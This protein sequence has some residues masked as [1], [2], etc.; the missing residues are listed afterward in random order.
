MCPLLCGPKRTKQ[1][2]VLQRRVVNA[3]SSW[4]WRL[5]AQHQIKMSAAPT[6]RNNYDMIKHQVHLKN[7]PIVQQQQESLVAWNSS[8]N[9]MMTPRNGRPT[10]TPPV[11][12]CCSG[13]AGL[14]TEYSSTNKKRL[15]DSF[16]RVMS[17]RPRVVQVCR[18]SFHR[19]IATPVTCGG[20]PSSSVPDSKS[21]YASDTAR[22][23]NGAAV[24]LLLSFCDDQ[25][26]SRRVIY[27]CYHL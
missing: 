4:W 11:I 9:Y 20:K 19:A 8:H 16:R 21:D 24:A 26:F 18:A 10:R 14:V 1:L 17:D 6:I 5:H 3:G 13:A 23:P 12:N 22:S 27:G 7:A 2:N 25:C 15:N